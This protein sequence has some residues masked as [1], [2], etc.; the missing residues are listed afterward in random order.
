MYLDFH[1]HAFNEKIAQ[2]AIS[3]LEKTA[4]YTAYTDGTLEDTR[5]KLIQNNISKAVLLP[6][7][8]KPSQQKVIN[9]WA[10]A[11]E[12]DFFISFGSVHPDADDVLDELERI[13]KIG[14]HGVKMHPDYINMF[15][16]DPKMIRVYRK[17]A[18]LDLPVIIHGGY[19][20]LSPELVHALPEASARAFD[21]VPEM[22]FIIAHLG[23]MYHW[24]EVEK[25]LVGKKGNLY[26]DIAVI[27]RAIEDNHLEYSQ[28][29]RI[30]KNHGVERIL[31]ASDCPWDCPANE[32]DIVNNHLNLTD[33]EKELI[34][35]KNA[36]K[37]LKLN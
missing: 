10:K 27:N 16:D 22:T 11:S 7:A 29:E 21:A 15:S 6:V 37:L 19:D 17:C 26:F 8:T 30:V 24:D 28:I 31:F 4:R 9:D 5:K 35:H 23:G 14:L 32:I 18:E 36:E 3:S 33:E 20:P 1:V 34:F 2:R 13:K 25:Y 12:D